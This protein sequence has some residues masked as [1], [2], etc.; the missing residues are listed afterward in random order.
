MPDFDFLFRKY[1][2][3]LLLYSLKYVESESDALDIVQNIF[4]AVWEN[5]KYKQSENLVKAYLFSSVKNSCLNYLK[6][7]KIVRQFE[8]ES[9]LYIR[10][11]EA[12]HYQSGEK[13]LIENESLKQINDAIDSLTEIYK[14]VI[15]LSRFEG[16]KNQEIAVKLNLP[17]RTVETRIFRALSTL[18]EKISQ[19]SFF[20]LL[21]LKG[22]QKK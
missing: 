1:H 4:V 9:G 16:L 12:I 14:E 19:K 15:L 13:S 20:I 7:Q 2:R 11:I 17:L 18:K 3:R 10:E 21:Y 5:G 6:H 8:H 22:L